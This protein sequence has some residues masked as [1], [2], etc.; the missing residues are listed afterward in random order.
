MSIFIFVLFL[1]QI[2]FFKIISQNLINEILNNIIQ[3]LAKILCCDSFFRKNQQINKVY[4]KNHFCQM[5]HPK[6]VVKNPIAE[7]DGD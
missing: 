1:C 3:K 5:Q 6:I 4:K 2:L 7:L